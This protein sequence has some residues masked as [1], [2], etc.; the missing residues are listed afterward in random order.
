MT[1]RSKLLE[2]INSGRLPANFSFFNDNHSVTAIDESINEWKQNT[3]CGDAVPFS[4]TNKGPISINQKPQNAAY[5]VGF[6]SEPAKGTDETRLNK[7]RRP[8]NPLPVSASGNLDL[9]L[10]IDAYSSPQQVG[11]SGSFISIDDKSR[12]NQ[13]FVRYQDDVLVKRDV[14]SNIRTP[15]I[16]FSGKDSYLYCDSAN[17]PSRLDADDTPKPDHLVSITGSTIYMS[18]TAIAADQK[19]YLFSVTSETGSFSPE[20]ETLSAEGSGFELNNTMHY[21]VTNTTGSDTSTK[22]YIAELKDDGTLSYADHTSV[23]VAGTQG[24][25][26]LIENVSSSLDFDLHVSEI[27]IYDSVHTS[28]EISGTLEYLYCKN[29]VLGSTSFVSSSFNFFHNVGTGG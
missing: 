2:L 28:A 19:P 7:V 16:I 14:G 10:H 9:V 4:V 1:A 27:L 18:F 3:S 5:S 17:D 23:S 20:I 12:F 22:I 8:I 26:I 25:I 15:N 6:G 13:R 29:E 24:N 11:H 21:C